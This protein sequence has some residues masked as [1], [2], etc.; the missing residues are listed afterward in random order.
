MNELFIF[1]TLITNSS[2]LIFDYIWKSFYDL[3]HFLGPPYIREVGDV[4]GVEGGWL[5]IVCPV[6]GYPIQSITWKKGKLNEI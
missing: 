1:T 6:S 3:V 5:Q 2:D 4:S